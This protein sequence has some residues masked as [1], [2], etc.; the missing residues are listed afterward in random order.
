MHLLRSLLG[1]AVFAASANAAA[2]LSYNEATDAP[3]GDLPGGVSPPL[4]SIGTLDVGV[5]TLTGSLSGTCALVTGTSTFYSCNSGNEDGQDSFELTIAKNTQLD[6][7]AVTV[8]TAMM[9]TGFA[10]GEHFIVDSLPIPTSTFF[11]RGAWGPSGT[12]D[13]LLENPVPGFPGLF[14]PPPFPAG[15]Y[16]AAL[17]AGTYP[18]DGGAEGPFSLDYTVEYRVSRIP[19]PPAIGLIVAALGLLLRAG[20]SGGAISR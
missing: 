3:A 16:F 14:D 11:S 20:R 6:S 1:V 18:V 8:E 9:P 4:P 5:N 12:T 7:V 15:S 17:S 19:A 2:A 10:G 13:N